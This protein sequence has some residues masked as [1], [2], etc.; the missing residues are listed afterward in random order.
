MN[1]IYEILIKRKVNFVEIAS[2]LS[3]FM[4]VPLQKIG[5]HEEYYDR[6]NTIDELAIGVNIDYFNQGFVTCVNIN[7]LDFDITDFQ[8]VQLACKLAETLATDIVINDLTDQEGF[9]YLIISPDKKYQKAY[10]SPQDEEN[11]KFT[12][13]TKNLDIYEYLNTLNIN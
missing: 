7:H 13:H 3:N 10:E 12:P 4:N 8:I 2:V 5:T 6:I 9:T 1:D 11:I